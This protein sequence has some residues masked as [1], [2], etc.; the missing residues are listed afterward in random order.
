[1]KQRK[2]PSVNVLLE[3]PAF[4]TILQQYG[5]T[6][7]R[8]SLRTVLDRKRVSIS[9]VSETDLAPERLAGD[10]L[11]Y[12]TEMMTCNVIP[13]FNATGTVLHTNLGR[14]PMAREALNAAVAAAEGYCNLELDLSTGQR[15]HRSDHVASTLKLLTGCEAAL[16]VNNNAGAVLLALAALSRGKE[17]ILSRGELIEIGG[18][19]RIPEV[20]ESSG[21]VLR[22][23]GTTNR[24]HFRDYQNA[25][26]EQ[27][28]MILKASTSN[29]AI[30]GFTAE[31]SLQELIQLGK[32]HRI[33]VMYDLG[34][35]NFFPSDSFGWSSPTARELLE[36][37]VDILT[38]SGDKLLG[39]P[40]AGIILGRQDLLARMASHPLARALRMDKMALAALDATL[41]LYLQPE[42]TVARIPCLQALCLSEEDIARRVKKLLGKLK[43]R[44]PDQWEL[45]IQKDTSPVGGG[46][47]P[48]TQLP[49]RVLSI[50]SGTCSAAVLADK[51]RSSRPPVIGRIQ[52][53]TIV[54]DLRTIPERDIDAFTDSLINALDSDEKKSGGCPR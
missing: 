10:T 17:V 51:L 1:M 19:F 54:L 28:G 9:S 40:Q 52:K 6:L 39:G 33:P 35:G 38:F 30:V 46:A 31:V 2:I 26:N 16:A 37:G 34:S 4:Q 22:E 27:T 45:S 21:A 53:D 24:T 8:N 48:L 23:V 20:L 5:R 3:D 13:V 43:G 11:K 12:M 42:K 47:L 49:T 50:R 15:G 44:V 29:Y 18:G 32:H 14:A 41:K 25:L 7:V 36:T